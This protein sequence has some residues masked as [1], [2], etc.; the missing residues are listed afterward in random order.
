MEHEKKQKSRPQQWEKGES[1]NPAGRPPGL[2][3][4]GKLRE[5]VGKEWDG[6]VNGLILAAKGGDTAA[7]SLLLS[8]TC[9]PMKPQAEPVAITATDGSLT[10]KASSIV[11]SALSGQIPPDV[12][13]M[14]LD[15]LGGLA[16]IAETEELTK[17]I[18]ALEAKL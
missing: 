10:G 3:L 16:R 2:T 1:G 7:A 14:L 5:A 4:A 17:R 12:A 15:G 9:P 11:D 18:E 8:R 6:I 13:K